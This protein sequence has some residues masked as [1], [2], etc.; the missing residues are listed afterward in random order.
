MTT[1]DSQHPQGSSS[2]EL[3]KAVAN[4]FTLDLAAGAIKVTDNYFSRITYI[5]PPVLLSA[6]NSVKIGKTA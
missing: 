2:R 5:L 1:E 3:N 6:K 4:Y